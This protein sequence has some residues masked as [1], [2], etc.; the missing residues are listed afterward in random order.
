MSGIPTLEL[1]DGD[2][3]SEEEKTEAGTKYAREH[4]GGTRGGAEPAEGE[5]RG[6]EQEVDEAMKGR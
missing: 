5:G 4:S 3:I 2:P 1:L 6:A